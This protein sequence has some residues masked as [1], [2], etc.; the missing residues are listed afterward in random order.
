MIGSSCVGALVIIESLASG[1]LSAETMKPQ[2][3]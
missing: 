2:L 1:G 3:G